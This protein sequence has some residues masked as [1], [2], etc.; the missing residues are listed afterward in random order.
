MTMSNTS[1]FSTIFIHI[2]KTAGTTLRSIIEDHFPAEQLYLLYIGNALHPGMEEFSGLTDEEKRKF[3]I[4]CGH[5]SFGFHRHLPQPSKYIT[6]LRDPVDRT[7]SLY[8]HLLQEKHARDD[9]SV[10]DIQSRIKRDNLTL[11]GFVASGITLDTDNAQTRILS[12]TS[13]KFGQCGRQTLEDAKSNLRDHFLVAGFTERFDESVMLLHKLL[14]WPVPFYVKKNIST[15]RSKT[16]VLPQSTLETI[17][18]YNE[19]DA[20]LYR[21]AQEIFDAQIEEQ[22]ATFK[23]DVEDFKN[24]NR[25]AKDLLQD[26]PAKALLQKQIDDL[27]NSWSWKITAPMR[28]LVEMVKK[29]Q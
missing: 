21:Y 6:V 15:N 11:E 28:K 10:A 1:N 4:F 25:F 3:K 7:V 19:L 12:G 2:P 9:Q 22:G 5:L 8:H 13:P 27:M 24:A 20:E 16:G 18:Q 29:Q 23:K 14:G 17:K 26:L